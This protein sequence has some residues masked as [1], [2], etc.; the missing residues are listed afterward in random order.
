ME[1]GTPC[2]LSGLD[3]CCRFQRPSTLSS[4]STDEH[5]TESAILLIT[6]VGSNESF[7]ESTVPALLEEV[8]TEQP[9]TDTPTTDYPQPIKE[10]GSNPFPIVQQSEV[11]EQEKDTQVALL[12][13]QEFWKTNSRPFLGKADQVLFI[14]NRLHPLNN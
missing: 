12:L 8:N 14:R 9:I 5:S 13:D 2:G 10:K 4:V 7:Q 6:A 3:V 1:F 11:K